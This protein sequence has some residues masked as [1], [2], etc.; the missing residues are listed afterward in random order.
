MSNII[1]GQK[2]QYSTGNIFSCLKPG[3]MSFQIFISFKNIL[4]NCPDIHYVGFLL[5][6]QL[7]GIHD[8]LKCSAMH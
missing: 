7:I 4:Q 6:T 5:K 8:V 3:H 2:L 1:L